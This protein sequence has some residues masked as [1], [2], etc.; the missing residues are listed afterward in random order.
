MIITLFI[1]PTKTN[2][3]IGAEIVQQNKSECNNINHDQIATTITHLGRY[4][5]TI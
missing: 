2:T 3:Q 5:Q 1:E 4:V